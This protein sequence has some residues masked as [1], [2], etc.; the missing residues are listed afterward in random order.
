ML[1]VIYW[2]PEEDV[3]LKILS[4]LQYFILR[5]KRKSGP[6]SSPDFVAYTSS[7]LLC[8]Q[9]QPRWAIIQSLLFQSCECRKEL[10]IQDATLQ[11]DSCFRKLVYGRLQF[12]VLFCVVLNADPVV[13][14]VRGLARWILLARGAFGVFDDALA[15]AFVCSSS[16]PRLPF[17]SGCDEPATHSF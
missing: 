5:S 16:L 11:C 2:C 7:G 10:P 12:R 8:G 15:G 13:G 6:E 14:R 4:F 9:S 1:W 3:E 17:L